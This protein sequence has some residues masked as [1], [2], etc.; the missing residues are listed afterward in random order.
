[1]K[2]RIDDASKRRLNA[3]FA[4]DRVYISRNYTILSCSA[5]VTLN[6]DRLIPIPEENENVIGELRKIEKK[7]SIT[8]TKRLKKLFTPHIPYNF[9]DGEIS[10]H[11]DINPR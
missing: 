1:M 9:K 5:H 2:F 11:V 6:V 10:A 7:L 8:I 4:G 3:A